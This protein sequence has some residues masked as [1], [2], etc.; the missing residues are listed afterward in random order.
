MSYVLL[1]CYVMV[2]EAAAGKTGR[3]DLAGDF[4][5]STKPA[6]H[7]NVRT[8]H[9]AVGVASDAGGLLEP[10]VLVTVCSEFRAISYIYIHICIHTYIHTY[11]YDIAF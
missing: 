5:A 1:F 2:Y 11:I 3:P 8:F 9:S 10:V 6:T 4:L 7:D